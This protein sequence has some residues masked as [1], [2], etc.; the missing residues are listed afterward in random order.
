[1]SNAL[2]HTVAVP[3]PFIE[4]VCNRDFLIG[5]MDGGP[6]QNP[7][8][9]SNNIMFALTFLQFQWA[10][11]GSDVA[12]QRIDDVLDY[13]D[14]RQDPLTGLWQPPDG[15]DNYNALYAAYHFWPYYFW[16]GR[17]PQLIE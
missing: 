5:W 9:H 3:A 2:G 4:K 6:W 8:L 7:W 14:R 13:L 10:A 1:A 12:L 17:R 16:R 15:P 11:T